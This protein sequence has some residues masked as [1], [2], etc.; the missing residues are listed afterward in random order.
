MSDNYLDLS[1]INLRLKVQFLKTDGKPFVNSDD[2]QPALVNYSLNSLFRQSSIT[3]NGKNINSSDGHHAYR[4]YLETLINMSEES[5]NTHLKIAGWTDEG[6]NLDK[7]FD[8]SDLIYIKS[9]QINPKVLLSH[10]VLLEKIPALYHYKK[11]EIKPFIVA[12]RGNSISIDNIVNWNLPTSIFFFMI[13][14][15][16]YNGVFTKNPF[17]FS[18]NNMESFTLFVNGSP[19]CDPILTDFNN[20]NICARAYSSIFATSGNL[21]TVNGNLK[22]KEKFSHGYFILSY[23][24]TNDSSAPSP[25]CSSS[26]SNSGNLRIEARFSKPLLNTI[27]CLCYL[28]YD[29]CVSINKDRSVFIEY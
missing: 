2:E 6:T 4:S 9:C 7:I 17:V 11:V 15:D 16:S 1:S 5:K 21:H 8:N 14:N 13:E 3:L 29:A 20:E 22:T 12:P 19:K 24:L 10:Q 27:T 25:Y 26:M 28:Q 18:H 23:D